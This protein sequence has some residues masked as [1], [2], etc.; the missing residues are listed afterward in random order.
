MNLTQSGSDVVDF[1]L[2]LKFFFLQTKFNLHP[3]HSQTTQ[4]TTNIFTTITL[5]LYSQPSIIQY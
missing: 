4:L 5:L 1:I 3:T 2:L